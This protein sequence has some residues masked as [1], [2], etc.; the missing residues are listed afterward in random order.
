MATKAAAFPG[1]TRVQE[2]IRSLQTEA[3]KIIDRAG[4]EASRLLKNRR[5]TLDQVFAQAKALRSDLQKR[6]TKTIKLVES[7]A[8]AALSRVEAEA[9][10]R[11]ENLA[12]RLSLSSK[13]DVDQLAKRLSSLEKKVDD[14]LTAKSKA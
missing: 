11:V 1:V 14:L 6:T 10:K 8:E 13:K 7:R 5:K 12:H 3:Q 9:K 4:G 2:S